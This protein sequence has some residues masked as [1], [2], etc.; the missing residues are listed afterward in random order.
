MMSPLS[1]RSWKQRPYS[2][3][4]RQW[5]STP[6]VAAALVAALAVLSAC[7]TGGNTTTNTGQTS[8]L[9]ATATTLPTATPKPKPTSVPTTSLAYCQGL[10]SLTEVNSIMKP[11]APAT[12]IIFE[13]DT[14][15]HLSACS[16]AQ[17]QVIAVFAVFFLPLPAGTSLKSAAQQQLAKVHVPVGGSIGTTPVSGVGDQALYLSANIPT[18]AGM[19]YVADLVVA[20]GGILLGCAQ[21][22]TGSVPAA[23][24]SELTQACKVVISRL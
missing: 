10:L 24:Q 21:T 2:R 17:G 15:N 11:A 20:D 3:F 7:T 14:S 16:W 22:G 5:W 8:T 23:T 19:N 1:L 4:H 9:T 6:V 18:P 13:N 12:N